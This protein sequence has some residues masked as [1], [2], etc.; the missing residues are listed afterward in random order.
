VPVFAD[1]SYWIA[2][3]NPKDQL[4]QRARLVSASLQDPRVVTTEM[5]LV[6]LLNEFG[7][8]GPTLRAATLQ[9][10][11]CLVSNANTVVVPQSSELFASALSLYRERPDKD[12]GITDCASF[13]VM[14]QHGLS[15]ALTY[16]RHYEQAGFTALLR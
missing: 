12:W 13:I 16:D 7:A 14:Q 2:L 6:E 3:L 4:H 9:L 8:R 10:V 15:A 11:S 1:T 5:V